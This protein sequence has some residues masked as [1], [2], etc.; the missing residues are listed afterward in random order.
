MVSLLQSKSI[1]KNELLL[2]RLLDRTFKKACNV[3]TLDYKTELPRNIKKE[4]GKNIFG[5]QF[6]KL[7]TEIIK[8]SLM[9]A[10]KTMKKMSAANVNESYILT[11][12]AV[13][14]SKDLSQEASESIVRMLQDDAIYYEHPK[15]LS[16]RIVDLW[17]GEKYRAE[18]FA[19][20]FTADVATAT[21]VARYRQYGVRYMEFDAEL[22]D[23]TTNQCR[24]LNGVQ[25]DL[26]KESVDRYR[27]PLHHHCVKMGTKITTPLGEKN[28]EDIQVGDKVLTHLGHYMSVTDTMNHFPDKLVD[29][30][31]SSYHVRITPN[32]PILQWDMFNGV[33][34]WVNAGDLRDGSMICTVN[35]YESVSVVQECEPEQVYNISVSEDESYTANGIIVHNCRSGLV[36][37]TEDEYKPDMEFE[38]RNFDN[39]LDNP[40]DVTR[41]FKNIDTFNEKYRVS[42][43]TLDQDLAA[44]IM[45]E[46]GFS[47]GISG[48]DLSGLVQGVPG[49]V[50]FVPAKTVKEA[51]DWVRTNLGI[52]VDY[53]GLDISVA[54][55][56]NSAIARHADIDPLTAKHLK[57]VGSIKG[58]TRYLKSRGLVPDGYGIEDSAEFAHYWP[59]HQSL[60]VNEIYGGNRELFD[61]TLKRC[62]EK[63]SEGYTWLSKGCGTVKATFDHEF[64]HVL[65]DMYQVSFRED[66]IGPSG[67]D[68]HLKPSKVRRGLSIYGAENNKEC[69][70]EA[71]AEYMNADKPR[72]ISKTIG[73]YIKK[74]IDF[75][76]RTTR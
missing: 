6:D 28:I 5:L 23:R 55:E 39:V 11:Q 3:T 46:K 21:T 4:F 73:E 44:R 54:N 35:G 76:A 25:F 43:F 40:D 19:R 31:T 61:S 63:T 14:I 2:I 29:L 52:D 69:I 51:E 15:A 48:P 27:P 60:A 20:T 70:A 47:V 1:L 68:L 38:N 53:D 22:D 72:K 10:D 49:K 71:W 17:G 18:R 26:E 34:Q 67:L 56:F 62:T 45:F 33:Y 41:V 7:I 24:C 65:D 12:E 42:K 8:E 66:L 32:H 57:F 50:E 37:L 64:G 30:H 75:M 9:Y 58:E 16:K 13:R 36:P 59:K 74:E